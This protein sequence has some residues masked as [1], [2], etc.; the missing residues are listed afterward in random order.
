MGFPLIGSKNQ[1]DINERIK[2]SNGFKVVCL[3]CGRENVL[4][5]DVLENNVNL[6][7]D[8]MQFML[9]WEHMFIECEC[10]NLL[11]EDSL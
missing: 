7:K 2:K 1:E 9:S 3:N 6:K 5:R 11:Y 8:N 4:F 10:G